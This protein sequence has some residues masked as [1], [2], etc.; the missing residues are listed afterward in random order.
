MADEFL[1]AVQYTIPDEL[2]ELLSAR[3]DELQNADPHHLYSDHLFRL[4]IGKED[5]PNTEDVRLES[6]TSWDDWIFHRLNIL[7]SSRESNH[8]AKE[9]LSYKQHFFF[10]VGVAALRVFLQANVTGPPLDYNVASF[11]F[12]SSLAE[13]PAKLASLRAKLVASLTVDGIA[14]YKLVPYPELFCLASAIFTAP[15]IKKSVKTAPW[16]LLRV[17]VVHQYLLSELSSSLQ[18]QIFD[19]LNTVSRLLEGL[20]TRVDGS[21]EWQLE[22]AAIHLQHS[23]D[24]KAREDLEHAK[25]LTGLQHVLTGRLGKRTRYQEKETSQLVV[26]A[27]SADNAPSNGVASSAN[28]LDADESPDSGQKDE[29]QAAHP[30]QLSLNDDTLLES[31]SFNKES[32]DTSQPTVSNEDSIPSSLE[33]LDPSQQPSLTPL[34]SINLLTF[35]SSISNTKPADGLTREETLP[36]AERVISGGSTNWQIYTQALLVRSRIEGYKSRTTERGLLQLQA[37]VDQV[38]AD[39]ATDSQ[40]DGTKQAKSTFL[41]QPGREESAPASQRLRY[42]HL[43]ATPF[44]WELEA[45]LANRWTQLGGLRTALEIYERLEMWSE[46]TL[47]Y[48]ATDQEKK[49]QRILKRQLRHATS[50]PDAEVDEETELWDGP[51]RDPPPPDAP[52]LWCILADMDNDPALWQ[53]AWEVSGKRYARAQR[54]LG[55]YYWRENKLESAAESYAAALKVNQL[56]KES[57]FAYGCCLLELTRFQEAVEAFARCVQ[58]DNDDAEAWSNLAAALVRRGPQSHSNVPG[59]TDTDDNESDEL[60]QKA[61]IDEQRHLRDALRAFKRAATLKQNSARIYDNVLTIAASLTPPAYTDVVAA[62]QRIIELRGSVEGESCVDVKILGAL[63]RHVVST[64]PS[65]S[66]SVDTASSSDAVNSL[67]TTHRPGSLP[68]LVINLVKKHVQPLITRSA[69][70]WRIDAT[71][72]VWQNKASAALEA[73]ERAWRI[74]SSSSSFE[75]SSD[76]K[77]WKE[78]VQATLDLV[79]AYESLGPRERSEGLAAGTGELVARDWKFKARSAIRGIQG[80]GKD[81]WTDTEGWGQLDDRLR[82]LKGT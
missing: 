47:C 2:A 10:C 33:S 14:P 46:V 30:K 1:S 48:A 69:Q 76:E 68:A 19:G 39:T 70:L 29:L 82:Q 42:I 24:K 73:E 79:D 27:K 77:A 37:L 72:S 50:E 59:N 32:I 67:Q 11:L 44:R 58:L 71:L 66:S 21:V 55:R 22:C 5:N 43:L 16:A 17:N 52:R 75:S 64:Y 35:A 9:N 28:S 81:L 61:P 25:R 34:D 20:K 26:L 78:V 65:P 41:P 23:L 63:V 51:V 31:I 3:L 12:P 6:F 53:N 38:I 80:R 60:S 74:V 36:Y 49:A 45:E 56:N 18:D 13:K 7:L 57:W 4:L 54:S 40:G 8:D 62:Q 15:S